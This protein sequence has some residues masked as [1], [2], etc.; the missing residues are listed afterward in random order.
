MKLIGLIEKLINEHGTAAVMGERLIL[1]KEQAEAVENQFVHSQKENAALKTKITELESQVAYWT[2]KNEY[3][4]CQGALFKRKPEGG[5]DVCVY[6]PGCFGPMTSLMELTP[7]R[8]AR[9]KISVN[10]T[11]HD[12]SKVMEGLQ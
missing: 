12:L 9:C 6:C 7:F 4:E 11:A 3:V 1:I 10:F 2:K 8:C 5:Y